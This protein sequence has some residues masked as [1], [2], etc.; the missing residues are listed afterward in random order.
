MAGASP[1]KTFQPGP[2]PGLGITVFAGTGDRDAQYL[3]LD[4]LDD[5]FR[6]NYMQQQN[7]I[8][9]CVL[10]RANPKMRCFNISLFKLI[11]VN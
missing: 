6:T 9:R 8:C 5:T 4:A 2:L 11:I 10:D 1:G 3:H 7:P